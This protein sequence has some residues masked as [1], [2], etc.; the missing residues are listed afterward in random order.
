MRRLITLAL[1][2]PALSLAQHIEEEAPEAYQDER[3][4]TP[5][6]QHGD[7][8]DSRHPGHQA[9][10]KPAPAFRTN[11]VSGHSLMDDNDFPLPHMMDDD[12]FWMVMVDELELAH[13]DGETAAGLDAEGWWGT[14]LNRVWFKTE[15]EREHSEFEEL[16]LQLLYSRAIS[17]FWNLRAGI[18]HDVEPESR[19]WLA[20]SAEGLAPYWFETEA[21]LFITDGGQAEL[22]LEAEYELLLTQ[23]LILTPDI[24]I[25]LLADDE[26]ELGIGSGLSSAEL[27]LRLRYEIRREFAPYVGVQYERLFGDT[28]DFSQ[29]EG[30]ESS[31]FALLA[32]IRFWF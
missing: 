4:E 22:R 11:E 19:N 24:E 31:G 9:D 29:S 20:F 6:H 13:S 26:L 2:L 25:S 10:E 30:E 16:E 28:A 8:R 12:P 15:A 17:P 23:R 1:L 18:R 32:G 21:S 5:E 27:A 7:H 14:D 3:V